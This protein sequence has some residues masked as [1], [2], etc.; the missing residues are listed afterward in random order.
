MARPMTTVSR[1]Q[2]YDVQFQNALDLLPSN[3]IR[4]HLDDTSMNGVF[5]ISYNFQPLWTGKL[6]YVTHLGNMIQ[7]YPIIF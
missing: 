2:S 3:N 5:R 7:E 6:A 1:K 4:K